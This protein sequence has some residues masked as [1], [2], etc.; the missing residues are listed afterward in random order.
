[1]NAAEVEQGLRTFIAQET[2]ARAVAILN[3]VRLSGGASRETWSFD[4]R[5]DHADG[6]EELIEA[7]LRA[8]P[9]K[10]APSTPGRELEYWTIRAA[11]E[12]GVAAPEPL[13]DGDRDVFGV[14]FMI[15]RRVPGETLGPRLIRG[16]QYARARE[17]LP[18]DLARSLA[19]LH[20]AD[21]SKYPQLAGLPRA[22]PG[23]SPAQLELDTYENNLR[24]LSQ[25]PH[26]VF[27]LALRWLRARMPVFEPPVFV[28]G[29]FRLGNVIFDEDGLCAVL[30]W[31]LAH[32]GDPLEDLGW[33][34]M[35]SWRFGGLR[36]VAGVGDREPFFAAYE[37]AGGFPVD[38]Q[39]MRFWE[40]FSYLKWGIITVM[41]G[42][43]YLDGRN[44][45]VEHASIGRRPAE[46]EIE[47]LDLLQD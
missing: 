24:T 46:T 9:S 43:S 19:R 39:R 23:T 47:L 44:R 4:A 13:W 7:I 2:G 5:V 1:M 37:A 30:D 41:Q 28:H 33:V 3:P 21:T 8:E 38:P 14:K 15:M 12:N 22:A 36:P 20:R 45:N 35:R 40:I 27:E 10:G 29:D 26:P 32:F 11:W 31:E 17:V 6:R 25:A 34:M 18:A 16:D 42:A